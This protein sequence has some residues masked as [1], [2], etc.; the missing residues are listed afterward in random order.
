MKDAPFQHAIE[1]A[2]FRLFQRWLLRRPHE[3]VAAPGRRLGRL[4]HRLL[5]SKR[6]L[7]ERNMARVFP[8]LSDDDHRRLV[9]RCFEFYGANFFEVASTAR[10]DTADLLSRFE[11]EGTE[12]LDAALPG[13]RG[14]FLTTGHYGSWEP[15]IFPLADWAT[16]HGRT[17]HAVAR[18]LDNPKIDAEVR[19]GRERSGIEII[20]K[21]GAAYRMLNA[22]RRGGLV[23]VIIDQHVRE[24]AGIQVP[25]FG[26]EAWTSPV[27][28][29]LSLR[30]RVPV[31]PFTCVP[32]DP[33]RYR[34]TIHE[35]IEPLDAAASGMSE[36]QAEVEMTR[37]YL[38]AVEKDVRAQPDYW[39]WM[40]RRWR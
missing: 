25:F 21:A 11:I 18:P 35:P 24:S 9:E 40:H 2:A 8:E 13:Q 29:T 37:R 1:Y 4:A 39:L 38:A 27:L 26:E 15:A 3:A 19:A 10:L 34:L 31:V 33:G 30:T 20:D 23:A 6:R 12:H 22:C 36:E 16:K 32:G 17:C 7:A 14:C 28:A 5:R